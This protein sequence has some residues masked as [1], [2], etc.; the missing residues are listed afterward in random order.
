[1]WSVGARHGVRRP[2]LGRGCSEVR[3]WSG[4]I[5]LRP[6]ADRPASARRVPGEVTAGA[7]DAVLPRQGERPEQTRCHA[8]DHAWRRGTVT[9][10]PT[11]GGGRRLSGGERTGHAIR[12]VVHAEVDARRAGDEV[13]ACVCGRDGGSH[14]VGVH[15]N[16]PVPARDRPC[17]G[18]EA[19]HERDP[20]QRQ[21]PRAVRLRRERVR[22]SGAAVRGGAARAPACAC[23][24][25]RRRR[26]RPRSER[27]ATTCSSS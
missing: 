20:E 10:R 13:R 4:A 11:E 7:A 27:A 22:R 25:S 8:D 2:V 5:H 3:R 6:H 24:R 17:G 12:G 14:A 18:R 23:R 15:E 19:R 21:G 1:M 16:H 9:A 26:R